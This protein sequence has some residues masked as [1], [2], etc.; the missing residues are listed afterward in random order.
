MAR[1]FLAYFI[2]HPAIKLKVA[3]PKI[4]TLSGDNPVIQWMKSG[5]CW[6]EAELPIQPAPEGRSVCSNQ[7]EIGAVAPEERPAISPIRE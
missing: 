1:K 2:T 7:M 3:L 4:N 5:D 6:K